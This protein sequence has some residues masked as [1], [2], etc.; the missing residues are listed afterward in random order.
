MSSYAK[1]KAFVQEL[2]DIVPIN[3]EFIFIGYF[4]CLNREKKFDSRT[5][6]IIISENYRELQNTGK[7]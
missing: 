6:N 7:F 5:S 3:E 4:K 2:K 1:V